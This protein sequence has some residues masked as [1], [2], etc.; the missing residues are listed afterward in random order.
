[1]SETHGNI[2]VIPARGGSKR[3]AGKNV[4]PFAGRPLIEYAISL[5]RKSGLF[6]RVI[7]S[8]DSAEV[9]EVAEN[10]GAEVP[11]L[12][13]AELADDHATTA[14]LFRHAL[15]ELEADSRYA[16]A[17]CIYPA[18]P[19]STVADLR[20][21]LALVA[22]RGAAS[23]FAVTG[24]A[25]PIWRAFEYKEDGSLAMVWPE[26]R[27][28]RSQD[29]PECVHDVGQFYWVP[30][31]AFLNEPVLFSEHARG[32]VYERWR[33]HDIDTE[34]DWILAETIYRALVAEGRLAS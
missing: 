15:S 5:A 22:E 18:V 23:S 13:P 33:A 25:A 4:R 34:E 11:F 6:E 20:A 32:V 9:G 28:T 16:H 2:A 17:C 30:V 14:A 19:F 29:L 31:G 24:F 21:G 26:H 7:I 3:I 12:R 1:M 10:A 27:D 8:T